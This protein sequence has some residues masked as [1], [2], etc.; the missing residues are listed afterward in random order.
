MMG[1]LPDNT[2]PNCLSPEMESYK[3]TSKYSE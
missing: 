1:L 2:L 3:E